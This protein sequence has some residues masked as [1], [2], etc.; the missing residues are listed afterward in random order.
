MIDGI[1]KGVVL[2][3]VEYL[4]PL[5]MLRMARLFLYTGFAC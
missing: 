4:M 5:Q 3:R 2:G 1:G